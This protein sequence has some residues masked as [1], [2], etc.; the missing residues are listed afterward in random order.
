MPNSI[1]ASAARYVVEAY[2]VTVGKFKSLAELGLLLELRLPW[3]SV[4]TRGARRV[5]RANANPPLT[6]RVG[7][8]K[9]INEMPY[10]VSIFRIGQTRNELFYRACSDVPH[11]NRLQH[12]VVQAANLRFV[13]DCLAILVIVE[14]EY[15]NAVVPKVKETAQRGKC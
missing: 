4:P 6:D 7:Q 12:R 8:R 1:T 2:N 3:D 11:R 9:N 14:H 13:V 5:Q 10:V 15:C